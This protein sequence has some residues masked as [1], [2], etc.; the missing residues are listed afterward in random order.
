MSYTEAE[1]GPSEQR[2]WRW[3]REKTPVLLP[4]QLSTDLGPDFKK[5]HLRALL[6][7]AGGSHLLRLA[8]PKVQYPTIR[9]A[10]LDADWVTAGQV[11]RRPAE[12]ATARAADAA[13]GWVPTADRPDASEATR[14]AESLWQ[15]VVEDPEPHS[16]A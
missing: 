10:L 3:E 5:G 16:R 12:P 9:P 6:S 15:A 4:S 8:W 2:S 1:S 13:A 7:V 14:L 11:D